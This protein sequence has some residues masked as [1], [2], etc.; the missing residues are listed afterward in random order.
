[1]SGGPNQRKNTRQ[2][3]DLHETP[4]LA[5]KALLRVEQLPWLVWDPCCG[6]GSIVSVLRQSGHSVVASDVTD[7][8]WGQDAVYDF[9]SKR[10]LPPIAEGIVMN[11]PYNLAPQFISHALD[12]V[13]NVYALLRLNFYAA[14]RKDYPNL[15][16]RFLALHVFNRRLPMMHRAG[17]TGKKA[18]SMFDHA[19]FVWGPNPGHIAIV[20]QIDWKAP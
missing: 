6:P 10:R 1:M 18:S 19:W 16:D 7:Y 17:Y 13:P 5:V 20:D 8:E 9:L 2:T 12:L 14:V 11:P 4:S 3:N 15:Y